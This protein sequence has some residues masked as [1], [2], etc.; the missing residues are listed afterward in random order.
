[1]TKKVFPLNKL[2]FL[3]QYV[4]K[5]PYIHLN[6]KLITLWTALKNIP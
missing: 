5:I 4:T 1:M 6:R 3:H 2:E